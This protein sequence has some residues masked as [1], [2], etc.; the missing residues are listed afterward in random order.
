MLKLTSAIMFVPPRNEQK[1]INEHSL[2]MYDFF[3]IL[4]FAFYGVI[5]VRKMIGGVTANSRRLE[6]NDM[7]RCRFMCRTYRSL[8]VVMQ[9]EHPFANK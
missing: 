8:L 9:I 1:N 7:H 3:A 5:L 4:V 6:Y 2:R